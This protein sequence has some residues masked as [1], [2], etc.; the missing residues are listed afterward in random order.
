VKNT[1]ISEE[2]P[3]LQVSQYCCAQKPTASSTW[4]CYT[5]THPSFRWGEC[6]TAVLQYGHETSLISVRCSKLLKP[7]T[8]FKC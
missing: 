4:V 6:H 1:K 7:K 5:G 2:I 3:I 8:S